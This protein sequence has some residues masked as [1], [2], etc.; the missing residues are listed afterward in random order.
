MP[1]LRFSKLRLIL[2]IANRIWVDFDTSLAKY[3]FEFEIYQ[4]RILPTPKAAHSGSLTY[5]RSYNR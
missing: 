2:P 5:E 1:S 3:S 4:L